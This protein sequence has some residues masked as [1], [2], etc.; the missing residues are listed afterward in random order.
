VVHRDL[1]PENLF[2]VA[3]PTG[4][5]VKVLDFGI[6]KLVGSNTLKT[7]DSIIIGTPQYMSPEQA[8]AEHDRITGQSDLF[9]LA[10]VCFEALTGRNP[11]AASTLARVVYLVAIEPSPSLRSEPLGLPE[12]VTD[13][14][15]RALAKLPEDRQPDVAAFVLAFAG[16]SLGGVAAGAAVSSPAEGAA[17]GTPTT[18]ARAPK[19]ATP[20]PSAS[21]P[22]AQVPTVGPGDGPLPPQDTPTWA[23][24]RGLV[25]GVLAFV[26]GGVGAVRWAQSNL[27]SAEVG[28]GAGALLAPLQVSADASSTGGANATAFDAGGGVDAGT[29]DAGSTDASVALAA[30]AAPD[31]GR[32]TAPPARSPTLAPL[33]AEQAA[34]LASAGEAARG[35]KWQ[36]VIDWAMKPAV[37]ERPEAVTLR[38]LAACHLGDLGRV[39]ADEARLPARSRAE[40]VKACAAH[41]IDL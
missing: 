16:V 29:T 26:L 8:S 30:P 36:E 10:T 5:Q 32:R 17:S 4:V 22:R 28:A 38:V 34:V 7:S 9:S 15:D 33:T 6:S 3:T 14:V 13:A 12:H 18:S 27:P 41:G 1:K 20:R 25:M 2:L 21:G 35:S 37:A 23:G 19:T 24:T 11:F 31:A 40:V 39:R